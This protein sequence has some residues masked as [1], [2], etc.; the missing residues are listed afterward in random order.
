MDLRF[1]AA[2]CLAA[3]IFAQQDGFTLIEVISKPDPCERL[4]KAGDQMV[5]HYTGWLEKD[6]TKFDSSYD[7]PN[8]FTFVLGQGQVIKGWD[9]GL[10]GM[11]KGE[12][13]KLTVPPEMGY[14][15]RGAGNIIPGGATLVFD[16]E[17]I[18]IHDAAPQPNVFKQIDA[19]ADNKLSKVELF[20]F[21]DNQVQQHKEQGGAEKQ[22]IDTDK[23]IAEIFE[24]EDTDKDGFI[25]KEEFRGPKHDEL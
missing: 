21:I 16:T 13:R 18:D 1:L 24:N 9:Q 8:P 22:P 15:D 23:I 3:A 20:K 12:K 7:R 5:M 14:G 19:D 25:S 2:L 6:G 4:S 11:C 17:L 10:I